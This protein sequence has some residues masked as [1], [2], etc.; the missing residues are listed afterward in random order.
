[1][2]PDCWWLRFLNHHPVT[3][4]PANQRKGM[5]TAALISN[6]AFKNPYLK[7]IK[8]FRSFWAWTSHSPSLVLAI[9]AV[10]VLATTLCQWVGSAARQASRS[11]F[12]LV[13][14]CVPQ[15]SSTSSPS[16]WQK[17]RI[18]GPTQDCW[19]KVYI[20]TKSQR[21][22]M[23]TPVWRS[24]IWMNSC[25]FFLEWSSLGLHCPVLLPSCIKSFFNYIQFALEIPTFIFNLH[26]QEDGQRKSN[27]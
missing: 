3:S 22:P 21:V 15:T 14:E 7:V 19:S 8:D 20:L 16:A 1:M 5:H 11:K 27:I 2:E 12:C 26:S 6:D 4:S 10:L 9:K 23:N 25:R 17:N 18:S 24:L 13:T